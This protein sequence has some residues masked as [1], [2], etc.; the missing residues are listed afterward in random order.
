M[1]FNSSIPLGTDPMIKSQKQTRSNF[2][3]INSVFAENHVR[4][5]DAFQGMHNF[6]VFRPQTGDPTT[7]STQ[8]ALYTKTVSQIPQLF[9]AP[10]SSQTPIQMTYTNP[11]SGIQTTNPDVYFADQYSTLAGPFI[12]YGGLIKGVTNG[13]TKI[14]TP[15]ST[16]IYAGA[17]TVFIDNSLNRTV[18][19][20][21]AG[22][23]ITFGNLSGSP[24]DVYYIAI[25][26]P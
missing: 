21:F 14:L 10:S 13:S 20:T 19:L 22:S 25:G 5:N 8:I 16:L 18:S 17:K 11:Q 1:S 26:Q 6:M 9:F 15:T 2:Q 7:S 24:F 4:M 12:F 23:T 3:A